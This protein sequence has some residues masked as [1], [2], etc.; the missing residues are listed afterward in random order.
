MSQHT[1]RA[2][3]WRTRWAAVGAAVAVTLGAGGL[4]AAQAAD[5]ESNVVTIDP[6]R[7]VDTRIDLG[8]TG[9]LD[10][11][12]PQDVKA[13]GMVDT[14][15]GP[16]V[17]VPDGAT[18]IMM[19][20]S[21]VLPEA[22]GFV[23]ARPG[24]ATGTVST[25]SLNFDELQTTGN[26]VTVI[27]PTTGPDVG[28]FNLTYDAYGQAGPMTNVTVDVVGYLTNAT[29]AEM[30]ARL[31]A[32]ESSQPTTA[33][34]SG[35]ETKTLTTTPDDYAMVSLEAPVDGRVFVDAT[36]TQYNNDGVQRL[37][38]CSISLM[39]MTPDNATAHRTWIPATSAESASTGRSFPVSA[40]ETFT[41]YL[42]C[43]QTQVLTS[44]NI[45]RPEMNAV[46]VAS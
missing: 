22:R 15:D 31:D 29:I 24:G 34:A 32:L 44:A 14:T 25:A 3:N 6:V 33:S 30:S 20:V 35:E 9:P 18:G 8:I 19:N 5:E 26:A 13:T 1:T 36:W 37:G 38:I 28:E 16:A 41:A 42:V 43:E 21:V 11:L 45:Q 39:S 40:G 27:L 46:F 17:V 10:S 7:I 4:F 23:T 12:Q 2:G